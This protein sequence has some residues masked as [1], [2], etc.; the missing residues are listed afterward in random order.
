[1][2]F[3]KKIA[4]SVKIFWHGLF[5]S[6]KNTEDATLHA[7]AVDGGLSIGVIQEVNEHRV[8][9]ALL[10]GEVTQEVKELRHRT[11]VV[12]REA[13]N[14][15]YYTPTL[16]LKRTE[17]DYKFIK[18]DDSDGLELVTVQPNR[19]IPMNVYDMLKD[20]DSENTVTDKKTGEINVDIGRLPHNHQHIIEVTRK[21]FTPRYR[22]E[23]YITMVSVK[24]DGENAVVGIYVSIYPN[25][26]DFKSKGFVREIE[27][28][29]NDGV[30]SDVIDLE[31]L[32][33]V[34]RHAYRIQDMV[35]F[36][37]VNLKLRDIAEF[38]GHYVINMTADIAV[39]GE[40]T[41][42]QYTDERM[43]EKYEKKESKNSTMYLDPKAIFNTRT[44]KC[45]C[46]GKEVLYSVADIDTLPMTEAREID[47][48]R[49]TTNVTGGFDLEVAEQTF[50]KRLC[51]A[52]MKKHMAELMKRKTELLEK[53]GN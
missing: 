51:S 49:E 28:I 20:I 33:F 31:S 21:G 32:S 27:K 13:K 44:Y 41:M 42:Q 19:E 45:E 37:F 1:M 39:N 7:T 24:K 53:E 29:K 9:K 46:C 3:F 50:G 23:D 26:K 5:R 40:D 30:R 8:S 47:E 14:Y 43:A 25:D 18:Y 10:K 22:I 34:T 38:D 48:E 12:D 15:D 11:Y 35:K 52:C 2:E 6:M 17:N 16:A 4:T 36:E